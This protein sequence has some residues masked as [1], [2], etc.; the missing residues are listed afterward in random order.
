MNEVTNTTVNETVAVETTE[1][2]T[3][4]E[5][6]QEPVVTS[7]EALAVKKAL[8]S[9]EFAKVLFE[10]R[11]DEVY[12]RNPDTGSFSPIIG[13]KSIVRTDTNQVLGVVSDRYHPLNNYKVLESVSDILNKS[14]IE[15]A[16]GKSFQKAGGSKTRMEFVFPT[17][18]IVVNGNDKSHLRMY[19]DN[20]FAA[21][22][23]VN[24]SM[25]F[26][27]LICSNGAVAG[28]TEESVSVRH[29]INV[30]AN[31]INYFMDFIGKKFDETTGFVNNLVDFDFASVKDAENF[32]KNQKYI[33]DRYSDKLFSTWNNSYQGSRNGWNVFNTVTE[34]ITHNIR[35]N[36]FAKTTVLS[37]LNRSFNKAFTGNG[38]IT[39]DKA[40]YQMIDPVSASL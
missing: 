32:L 37:E 2:S 18:E 8:T 35:A 22:G 38:V 27:R 21:K 7:L 10:I 40:D 33:A 11:K 25:G 23:A 15:F 6:A 17:K 36:E 26:F 24:I 28:K 19:V 5:T 16:M 13:K 29:L 39:L 14:N 1:L 9:D 3:V 4:N 34:I 30:D 12:S 20:D 31:A